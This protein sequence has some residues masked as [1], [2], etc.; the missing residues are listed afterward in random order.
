MSYEREKTRERDGE[1]LW[2]SL[3]YNKV[4]AAEGG[5]GGGRAAAWLSAAA[6][7]LGSSY[8]AAGDKLSARRSFTS[9][10]E[11][12]F[13]DFSIFLLRL[14]T[15]SFRR[16]TIHFPGATLLPGKLSELVALCVPFPPTPWLGRQG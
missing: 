4:L 10:L 16:P 3:A 8:F 5:A 13:I 12:H 7:D 11:T 2:G 1:A 9:L 15:P 6:A 14:L